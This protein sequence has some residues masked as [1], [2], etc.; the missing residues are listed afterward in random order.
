MVRPNVGT[1]LGGV[2]TGTGALGYKRDYLL[3]IDPISYYY[4]KFKDTGN[5]DLDDSMWEEAARQGKLE[6]LIDVLLQREKLTPE[7][8][9]VD[10]LQAGGQS[11]AEST[12][13]NSAMELNKQGVDLVS[14]WRDYGRG[15]FD[16][17]M[18]ALTIPL[19]SDNKIKDLPEGTYT[20]ETVEAFGEISEKQYAINSLNNYFL[21]FDAQAIQEWKQAH[22]FWSAIG[23]GFVSFAGHLVHGVTTAIEDVWNLGEGI[24]N[25]LMVGAALIFGDN[26]FAEANGGDMGGAFLFAFQDSEGD[27]IQRVNER[28]EQD[29]MEFDRKYCLYFNAETGEYDTYGKIITGVS[30]SIGYM[31][32]S[33]AVAI[34]TGGTSLGASGAALGGRLTATTAKTLAKSGIKQA[35]RKSSKLAPSLFYTQFA[36]GNVKDTVGMAAKNGI[37]YRDLNAGEVV[38]NAG[39]K[40]AAQWAIE[41]GLGK[42]LGF[43]T[44]ADKLIGIGISKAAVRIGATEAKALG[45]QAVQM[46][47]EAFKEGTEEVLQNLSDGLFDY[48][49]SKMGSNLSQIYEGRA[50]ESVN[51][52]NLVDAFVIGAVTNTVLGTVR[53]LRYI[54]ASQRAVGTTEAGDPV[55]L[56]AFQSMQLHE[57]MAA[58]AEWN[59]TLQDGRASVE[60]K[61]N[62]AFKISVAMKTIGSVFQHMGK[63]RAF[64]ANNI[65]L[66]YVNDEAKKEQIKK[67]SETG[68]AM[69][70]YNTF[71][72][73]RAEYV[74]KYIDA[75]TEEKIQKTLKANEKKL[76]D[77]GVTKITNI[78]TKKTKKDDP[79]TEVSEGVT[80]VVKDAL[81][82]FKVEAAIGVNADITSK[83]RNN[84]TLIAPQKLLETGDIKSLVESAAYEYVEE[85]ILGELDESQMDFLLGLYYDI[86]KGNNVDGNY[87]TIKEALQALLFDKEFYTECLIRSRAKP[88]VLNF[89][90]TIDEIIRETNEILLKDK[91]IEISAGIRLLNKVREN[92]TAGIIRYATMFG[93]I[94][95]SIIS[96]PLT[97]Q[98]QNNIFFNKNNLYTKFVNNAKLKDTNAISEK[99]LKDFNNVVRV[100]ETAG[101][102]TDMSLKNYLIEGASSKEYNRRLESYAILSVLIEVMNATKPD[103]ISKLVYLPYMTDRVYDNLYT[104]MFD[105][106]FGN[107]IKAIIKGSYDPNTLSIEAKAL[108]MSNVNRYDMNTDLGRYLFVNDAMQ[109]ISKNTLTVDT[110]G[111]IFKMVSARTFLKDEYLKGKDAAKKLFNDIKT[112]KIRTLSDISKMPFS[113]YNPRF[114][115]NIIYNPKPNE[116]DK[117]AFGIYNSSTNTIEINPI[118]NNNQLPTTILHEATHAVQHN[119]YLLRSTGK[120]K[121]KLGKLGVSQGGNAYSLSDATEYYKLQKYLVDNFPVY[122]KMM[123]DNYSSVDMNLAEATYWELDGEMKARLT[124]LLHLTDIGFTYNYDEG[125]LISP[126]SKETFSIV[127]NIA[128]KSSVLKNDKSDNRSAEELIF[129]DY[130]VTPEEIEQ[131]AQEKLGT[132]DIANAMSIVEGLN[133]IRNNNN[134]DKQQE[135]LHTAAEGYY[136]FKAHETVDSLGGMSQ[137][138]ADEEIMNRY[139]VSSKDIRNFLKEKLYNTKDPAIIA[140][141]QILMD[142][143]TKLNISTLSD[144]DIVLYRAALD[145]Y[146][147]K[148]NNKFAKLLNAPSQSQKLKIRKIEGDEKP[149]KY[150]SKTRIYISN[151]EADKSNLK[152]FK[153]KGRPIFMHQ[154]VKDFIVSTTSEFNEIK[155]SYIRDGILNGTLNYFD[156]TNF[157]ATAS[158]MSDFTFK[159][160]AKYVYKNEE[161]AKLTFGDYIKLKD[162]IEKYTA[163]SYLTYGKDVNVRKLTLDQMEALNNKA[164]EKSKTDAEFAEKFKKAISKTSY[165]FIDITDRNGNKKTIP[166]EITIDDKQLMPLF[167]NNYEGTLASLRRIMNLAKEIAYHQEGIS[168]E[169]HSSKYKG[170]STNWI[171]NRKEGDTDYLDLGNEQN[172]VQKDLDT[173]ERNDKID[174][175]EDYLRADAER[176]ITKIDESQVRNTWSKWMA[177][178]DNIVDQLTFASDEILNAKYLQVME[179]LGNTS[180]SMTKKI[181]KIPEAPDI[182]KQAPSPKNIKDKIRGKARNIRKRIAGEKVRYNWLI[183]E[184][185]QYIDPETKWLRQDYGKKSMSELK[186]MY[187]VL[188]R[189]DFELKK[190]IHEKEKD[191]AVK[192]ETR[193][194]IKKVEEKYRK[195]VEKQQQKIEKQKGKIEKLESK[196]RELSIEGI[197]ATFINTE[198]KPASK[199]VKQLLKNPWTKLKMNESQYLENDEAFVA[200][201]QEFYEAN[202]EALTK[203]TV[204][205]LVET[206]E[207]FMTST[208][209]VNPSSPM[210]KNYLAMQAYFFTD[211][212]N[213]QR[214]GLIDLNPER[215]KEYQLYM[216][217]LFGTGASILAIKS[218]I[219]DKL[220][221]FAAYRAA[222]MKIDGVEITQELKDGLFNAVEM[223]IS[224]NITAEQIELIKNAQQNIVQYVENHQTKKKSIFRKITSFRAMAMLSSPLTWLRNKVSN[225]AVKRLN[226]WSEKVGAKLFGNKSTTGQLQMSS[227]ASEA[228]NKYIQEQFVDNGLLNTLVSNISKYNPSDI[229]DKNRRNVAGKATKETIMSQLIIDAMFGQYYN[230]SAYKSEA[231]TKL[232]KGL[233]K[234]LSDEKYI[235][236]AALD[237]LG[238]IITEKSNTNEAYAK[239]ISNNEMTDGVMNDFAA[240][241]GLALSDYM[242]QDNVFNKVE[243]WC[244]EQN[245]LLWFG[246]K[247]IS[248]FA[249]TSWNWFKG[250]IR[251]SPIGL[252]RAIVNSVRLENRIKKIQERWEHGESQISGELAEYITKRDLGQGV[253]GTCLYILGILLAIFGI[254]RIEDDDYGKPKLSFFNGQLK[255]DI[256]SIFGSSSLLSGAALITGMQDKGVT[257]EGFVEGLNRSVDVTIDGFPLL[258]I[259]E[260]DMYSNGKWNIGVEQLE[261]IA[262]SFMP[263]IISWFAGGTYPGN[264]NKSEFI[265]RVLAK[266]P[267]VGNWLPKKVNPYTGEKGTWWDAFNRVVPYFSWEAANYVEATSKGLGLNKSQLRGSYTI[268]DKPFVVKGKDLEMVNKA[269]G[270]WNAADIEKFYNNKMAVTVKVGN[271]Y[272]T[273][274]FNQMDDAQRKA[275]VQNIM[276][277][278]AEL[279][280]I[281]A[282]TMK[283]NK[284]YA[285]DTEYSKIRAKG[286]KSNVYKGTKG[287]VEK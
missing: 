126:D 48:A 275:A 49:F 214:K 227:K 35:T 189:A 123:R 5:T 41:Y 69:N 88:K 144:E 134:I 133:T 140:P 113:K 64:A 110:Y 77:A 90:I 279:A 6:T 265:Y 287:F 12:G 235:R 176:K 218:H 75:K 103:N 179:G 273:L 57:S 20:P 8:K 262:I 115:C 163:L 104:G 180:K 205:E 145:Y 270:Q 22:A 9:G 13:S 260:M 10:Y 116:S 120:N 200:N 173:I 199:L 225:M 195:R 122:A 193:E 161:L 121:E 66:G 232:H 197:G 109:Y 247:L 234:M 56:G 204:D 59:R 114:N 229:R 65:L 149:K 236:S 7:Q 217:R 243:R 25:S 74:K 150:K 169:D 102:L 101:V 50:T 46:G 87:P 186:E 83:D 94:D 264:V 201:G 47:K 238:R 60:D 14:R 67:L 36:S 283:G 272:K 111:N 96:L 188:I 250:A 92:M 269:Y 172:N 167:F 139:N 3:D 255:V 117:D 184:A 266:I 142:M 17:Y 100:L 105:K 135:N 203:A 131:Y 281:Y 194:A 256:S 97:I 192:D 244:A 251:L 42:L 15:D 26:E 151:A 222:S 206:C 137:V 248:P 80:E 38:L 164:I 99:Q 223:N 215:A 21:S 240:A 226:G 268:N 81:D 257:W 53:N 54:P 143:R 253:I 62:A 44:T 271:K 71:A 221:P 237:Y 191:Q 276:T 166:T 259:L 160:I 136:N 138:N 148:I 183:E 23:D 11:K 70:L 152:Y 198:N 190:T 31:L 263:N 224:G 125:K 147:L 267:F 108:I 4:N 165:F 63:E 182:S 130:F 159:A 171:I 286:I 52:Q 85:E 162:N 187:E 220:N 154:G 202:S 178:I 254:V 274:R 228:S 213:R 210:F 118:G 174:A 282:W 79:E 157:V 280:K 51:I 211:V 33:I 177:N 175:I 30:E 28:F 18:T 72:K 239:A 40:A 27:P 112:R 91:P 241:F 277:N 128:K 132:S 249:A 242:H 208:I 219:T 196:I 107:S 261:S 32:P 76:K 181:S 212:I 19:L 82:A 245:D 155:E 43:F 106:Y 185:K 231:F 146:E 37:S 156:I 95:E 284:Y 216:T 68:Y 285:T 170:K 16:A 45:A 230:E 129:D 93:N 158:N 39:I 34:A 78:F 86:V 278:N 124:S 73:E 246:W 1:D 153:K 84:E 58:L 207:W 89:F 55:Q 141:A 2:Q 61:Q 127:A 98:I 119:T 258:N 29:L 233:M 24:I 209:N 168:L 252:A